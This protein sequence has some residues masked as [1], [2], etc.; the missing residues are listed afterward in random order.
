MFA[1]GKSN[2]L[3]SRQETL[4]MLA[5]SPKG[6]E[7][8]E[9]QGVLHALPGDVFARREVKQAVLELDARRKAMAE[10]HRLNEMLDSQNESTASC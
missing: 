9:H 1:Y 6:L 8:L 4:A 5:V 10:L 7:L 3:I 2:Q